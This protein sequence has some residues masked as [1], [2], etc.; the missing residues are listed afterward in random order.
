[1]SEES[2]DADAT[3]DSIKPGT[4]TKAADGFNSS[5]NDATWHKLTGEVFAVEGLGGATGYVSAVDA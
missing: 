3:E 5:T 2:S 4:A 1:M